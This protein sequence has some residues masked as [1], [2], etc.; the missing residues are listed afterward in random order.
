M[1]C[2]SIHPAVLRVSLFA[3]ASLVGFLLAGPV[4]H[5]L[6]GEGAD[7]EVIRACYLPDSGVVYRIGAHGLG[8]ACK[9][10]GHVEFSWNVQGP[11]GPQGPK[12]DRGP[13]G[14][15]GPGL[16]VQGCPAGEFVIGIDAHGNLA[17]SGVEDLRTWYLDFDGDGFGH[18]G[19]TTEAADQPSGYVA[20]G[21]DCDDSDA[22]IHAGAADP[23]GDDAFVRQALATPLEREPGARYGYSNVGYSLLGRIAE[24][25][26]GRPY[27]AALRE[28]VLEPASMTRTGYRLPPDVADDVA[29]GYRG[30]ERWG[31]I[32]ERPLAPDGA[33]GW[34]LRANGGLHSTVGDLY[35]LH[36]AL[37]RGGILEPS[38]RAA[39]ESP[40]VPEN[41]EGSSHYGFG[42]AIFETPRGTRLVA[43]NGGNGVLAAD[44]LRYVE[45]D[46]VVIVLSNTAEWPATRIASRV[47]ALVFDHDVAMPPEVAPFD[48]A[49][50]G[51][52]AG[53]YRLEDGDDLEVRRADGALVV[54]PRG[55][56][57]AE[58][59][60]G[61]APGDEA[62]AFGA[63]VLAARRAADAG[64]Y[65][66]LHAML[67]DGM[68]I[69]EIEEREGRMRERMEGRLG[70]RVATRL[71]GIR[72]RGG[73]AVATL[74][75]EHE[76]GSRYLHV[77]GMGEH[78][79]DLRL[80][81]EP[82]STLVYPATDGSWFAF[83]VRDGVTARVRFEEDG[84]VVLSATGE[85][86]AMGV[87]E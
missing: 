32:F 34:H 71:A 75:I 64:D 40:Q 8:D 37:E 44:F 31:T 39:M 55:P 11:V 65:G 14:P 86:R 74:E 60:S 22:S 21:T 17:C 67:G 61:T 48:K 35:R 24:E 36:V 27:E 81:P 76:R 80:S 87:G 52:H 42:W 59:L 19:V 57:A 70:P 15:P 10:E 50:A 12:G 3:G 77:A 58:A 18:P 7:G 30:G 66:P 79:H 69:R 4:V 28:R 1:S 41:P 85:P 83:D 2:F 49:V 56:R 25:V 20:T 29:V 72:E 73:E 43:H 63:R 6:A 38:T 47:A 84:I 45:D 53:T 26:T 78:V 33:P 9:A 5:A 16:T 82:V 68:S 54:V 62:R 46:V 51:G 23:V 13:Q